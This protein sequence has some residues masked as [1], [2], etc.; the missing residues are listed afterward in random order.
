MEIPILPNDFVHSCHVTRRTAMRWCR[1]GAPQWAVDL[2]RLRRGFLPWE[3]WAGW[4]IDNDGLQSPEGD[5]YHWS[6]IRAIPY[7]LEASHERY[8]QET[9]EMITRTLARQVVP[10]LPLIVSGEPNRQGLNR[11]SDPEAENKHP[12]DQ[13]KRFKAAPATR[14]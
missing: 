7:L 12:V 6:L 2:V 11:E 9:R 4:R 10:S 3:H 14:P 1:R 13:K 8:K 5:K